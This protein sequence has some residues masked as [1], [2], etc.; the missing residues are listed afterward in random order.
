MS[1]QGTSSSRVQEYELTHLNAAQG[2][3]IDQAAMVGVDNRSNRMSCNVAS[4]NERNSQRSLPTRSLASR[5][6]YLFRSFCCFVDNFWRIIYFWNYIQI[7]KWLRFYNKSKLVHDVISGVSVA[8]FHIPEGKCLFLLA[9]EFIFVL[10]FLAILYSYMA[11]VAASSCL[12]TGVIPNLV[13]AIMGTS[14]SVSVGSLGALSFINGFVVK[15][16]RDAMA[17]KDVAQSLSNEQ[18]SAS[19]SLLVGL[20]QLGAGICK[21]GNLTKYTSQCY[22][23]AISTAVAFSV[24]QPQL[25]HIFGLNIDTVQDKFPI[26]FNIKTIFTNYA[27][28]NWHTF[29]LCVFILALMYVHGECIVPRFPKC[30]SDINVSHSFLSIYLS[31]S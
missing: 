5:C 10:Y 9:S 17:A 23:S 4:F 7:F 8:S 28:I 13:Y 3:N 31:V 14:S 16:V 19:C 24:F 11:N 30:V 15:Y 27:E 29:G 6:R 22:W 18:I 25:V 20:L 12:K 2:N 1:Q 21:L 26:Y